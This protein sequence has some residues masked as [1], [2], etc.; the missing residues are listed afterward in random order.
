[1]KKL[2]LSSLLLISFFFIPAVYS[3]E[4]SFEQMM[5]QKELNP[6][7]YL[8]AKRFAVNQELPISIKLPHGILIDV[9]KEENGTI[10]Y[11][12]IKNVL[13]PFSDG[14]IL[15]YNQ[16]AERYDLSN[17]EINWGKHS[18][19]P[20]EQN[21]SDTKLLLVPD[22]TNDNVSSFDP[23]T[24][25]LINVNYIPSS[26]GILNSPKHALLNTAGFISVSDQ[27]TDLV[28]KFDTLGTY[29][30]YLAPA[31]GVNTS[32]L[33]NIRGHA[34]KP[35][36]NL[37]VTVGS[38]GN[39]NAIPE[40][41]AG[42]N[43]LGNFIPA[44]SGGLNSP[45]CIL[46]RA[47]D[48][49][50]TGSSSDAAH[51]YDYNGAYLG[52]LI[53]GVQFPQQIIELPNGNLALAIFSTPSGLGIYDSNGNQ[54]NFFTQ[55]TGLRGVYQLP[56]GNYL[57]TNS[58]GLHEIDGTNGNLIQTIYSST[59]F[60]YISYVDYSTIPVE[61]T[62][63]TA[64]VVGSDVVLN[65]QTAT[66]LNNSGFDVE[67]S[68]DNIN[69]SKIAFVP[70]FGTTTEPKSYSYTDQSISS[71]SYYYRLKQIDYDGSFSY[72]EVVEVE[73]PLVTEFALEQNYPNPFNPS[74][75]I[76]FNLPEKEFVTLKIYDVMGNEIATLIREEKS[77]GNHTINY[78]ASEL[79]SG[80]YFYKLQAGSNIET[81][82]ML[83]LK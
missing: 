8:E 56:S 24:G 51:R 38:S 62:L 54:L 58:G 69:F 1:M 31:G 40:F 45:F 3:Q 6:S 48:I 66:E 39:Q 28:Q 80:T 11:S 19:E 74:T 7:I 50:I 30:G 17:A 59:N 75:T 2:F 78:D 76:R 12:V 79:S 4:S 13:H 82:K 23:L 47:S 16:I 70:G 83:L 64:N 68:E 72:S 77:A 21:R 33:D 42:G 41:D 52:D 55:V 32:I 20:I 43:Y 26:P 65:W 25:A 22:W 46:Y 15:T 18:G 37:L 71:G 57:V 67:R 49:L 60:Q 73:M 44:G 9:L 27:L 5:I 35:N 53:T 14:E 81:H 61:L 63:F 36:G 10:L 29:L 34:Y